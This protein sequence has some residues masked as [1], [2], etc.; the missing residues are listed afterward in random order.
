MDLG[1]IFFTGLTVGGFTCMAVQGGLLASIIAARES[2][3][4]QSGQHKKHTTWP[5]L[6]FLFTKFLVYILFG[7][8]LGAFGGALSLSDEART[9][10]QFAAGLYMVAVALDLLKVHPIFR[11][12]VI[13]PPKF[14]VKKLRDT[15]KS[16]DLFAPAFLGGLTIFI[17]CGTT[18]AMEAL[19]ISSGSAIKGAL[20][21]G[22]FVL[23]TTP[24]FF[25]LGWLTTVLGDALREKFFKV[26]AVAVLYLGLSSV[27]AS[28]IAMGSPIT[29][30]KIKEASPIEVNF[31][32]VEDDSPSLKIIDGVSVADIKVFPSAYVP[33]I[34][35]VKA[36]MPIRLNL[37]TTGGYG[38]SSA[39]TIPS[40]GIRQRLPKNTTT[41]IDLPAQSPGKITFAC[42]MGMYSGVIEVVE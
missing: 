19:A 6:V 27:N 29:W 18:L 15:S 39:F 25:G 4:L 41:T 3:D 10:M 2:D 5:L 16:K 35:Q 40:L 32:G 36:A 33:R 11:Y 17:P 1:V 24:L 23:G 22:A 13:Q 7:F 31:G 20:I 21:M 12:A 38:C 14:L 37:T 8:V 34:V 30:D 26:A 28:L 9:V 42:S